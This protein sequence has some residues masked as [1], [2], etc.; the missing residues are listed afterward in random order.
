[1]SEPEITHDDTET[2]WRALA[3]W[4]D[5]RG[6]II[7][8]EGTRHTDVTPAQFAAIDYLCDEW[9]YGWRGLK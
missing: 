4:K 8:P 2:A 3:G 6:I 7:A 1:M 5:E 9:D